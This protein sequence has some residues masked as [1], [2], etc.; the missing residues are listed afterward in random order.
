MIVPPAPVATVPES[1]CTVTC[2]RA[3]VK[4]AESSASFC[5]SGP[6][7]TAPARLA[8]RTSQRS[9][10]RMIFTVA[11]ST[12][13][14]S[15]AKRVVDSFLGCGVGAE[16]AWARF[17]A[18]S[19]ST[20]RRSTPSIVSVSRPMPPP[21]TIDQ[22]SYAAV[23]RRAPRM[24]RPSSVTRRSRSSTPVK[25]SPSSAPI[26]M[27]P[28][29]PAL[30]RA[31]ICRRSQPRNVAVCEKIA[32][33]PTTTTSATPSQSRTRIQRRP[34]V[35]IRIPQ[36]ACPMLKWTCQLASPGG[37][38]NGNPRSRRSGPTMV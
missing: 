24:R 33:A 8:C 6:V 30:T 4:A 32:A 21:V 14:R 10:G 5:P 29:M 11:S 20:S 3:S 22:R 26:A 15:I 16:S 28:R 17:H 25:R 37:G 7:A 19:R 13:R 12:T 18:P 23:A 35:A 31:T 1:A 38:W 2:R 36:N 34:R 27:R 9:P